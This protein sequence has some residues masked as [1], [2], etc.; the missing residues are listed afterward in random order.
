MKRLYLAEI[1]EEFAFDSY[2]HYSVSDVMFVLLPRNGVF[3][4][5]DAPNLLARW[6]LLKPDFTGS[7]G[8]C[9]CA[10]IR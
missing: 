10:S 4:K 9:D 5:F 1:P 2:T 3:T 7:S 6:N 8:R